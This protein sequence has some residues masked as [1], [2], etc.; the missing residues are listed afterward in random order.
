LCGTDDPLTT[1]VIS[2]IVI[3]GA[4]HVPEGDPAWII[5]GS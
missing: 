1:P 3:H 2:V 4:R 5:E